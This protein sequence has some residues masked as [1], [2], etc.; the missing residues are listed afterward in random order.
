MTSFKK[1]ILVVLVSQLL[2]SAFYPF[3]DT[4]EARYADIARRMLALEDW[5]TPWF[6]NNVPFWGK[7]PLSFWVTLIGFKIFGLNELGGRFFYWITS[8]I[9]L[10]LTYQTAK[11]S[12]KNFGIYSMAILLSCL[13]FY[14]S[15]TAVMTD[16][17]LL[18]GASL[19]LYA[20][21]K[22]I[23]SENPQRNFNAFILGVGLAIG[24]LAKGPIA[25][26]IFLS[27][28]VL[29][30]IKKENFRTFQ[31][32]INIWLVIF[33]SI[34]ISTPWYLIA[35][36][37]TPGFLEYFLVGEHLNRYLVPGWKGDLYG[38]AH[39]F[40]KGT[41]LYF[42]LLA[43]VPWS[44]IFLWIGFRSNLKFPSLGKISEPAY[45]LL[46]LWVFVPLLF[47]S[48]AGNVIW[49]YMLPSLPAF[50]ILM[51]DLISKKLH[52]KSAEKLIVFS[53]IA[54]SII[55]II[56][57]SHIYFDGYVYDRTAKYFIEDI[58]NKNIPLNNVYFAEKIPFS[59]RF[60]GRG[61][62]N[63]END[64]VLHKS[65]DK[66][67]YYLV[68]HKHKPKFAYKKACN[69]TVLKRGKFTLLHCK[70]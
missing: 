32:G 63:L 59:A 30:M 29:W 8:L 34:V 19:A 7:P 10:F 38:V 15:S 6:D 17:P 24:M 33:V 36:I 9:V 45:Q 43:T 42:F 68:I 11:C 4:T 35:E 37:K 55:K 39:D 70:S 49:T 46:V 31:Q 18:L 28:L 2:L 69:E 58:K 22:C 62:F 47:F 64:S 54:V 25:L 41:I 65:K 20:Q 50:S 53:L 12:S 40:P 16:M 66:S 27:P 21:I 26:V 5:I 1:V 67:G 3:M 52:I 13:L 56:F 51:T 14:I 61:V 23:H 44:I 57:L 60:Y 48:F